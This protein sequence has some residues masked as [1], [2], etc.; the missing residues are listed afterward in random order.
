[1]EMIISILKKKNGTMKQ[2]VNSRGDGNTI[3]VAGR[4][5]VESDNNTRHDQKTVSNS[6]LKGSKDSVFIVH[7]RDDFVK[8]AVA[9]FIEQLGLQALIL[10]EQPNEGKAIIEKFEYYSST[11]KYAVIL[12]TP[13]DVGGFALDQSNLSPRARQNVIFEM[14]F[15]FGKLGRSNVCALHQGIEL[16]SDL[17]GILYIQLDKYGEWKKPLKEELKKA[18]LKFL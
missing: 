3:R 2:E 10:H 17:Q 12:L 4:D 7:G 6:P 15:F 11:V 16:P 5:I 14:G 18:G 13:D 1:M 9:R 8:D